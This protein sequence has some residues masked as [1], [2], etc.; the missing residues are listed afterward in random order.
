MYCLS[1]RCVCSL[2]SSAESWLLT[3]LSC[4]ISQQPVRCCAAAMGSTPRA[5]ASASVAGRAP[6]VTCRLP[7]VLTLSAGAVGFVSWAL[8]RA[9]QD[10]K[11]KVVKKVNMSI[12]PEV[13]CYLHK[14]TDYSCNLLVVQLN[15]C[16]CI[17]MKVIRIFI[18]M[19][20]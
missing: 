1:Q 20:A 9:T 18:F 10:T 14:A 13:Y 15:L 7:S 16:V 12:F 4:F 3:L 8:V 17:L 19:D 6:S 5:V 2:R 11:E